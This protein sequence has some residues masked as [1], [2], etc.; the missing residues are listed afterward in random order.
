MITGR[1]STNAQIECIS[2]KK[3]SSGT[4]VGP[5]MSNSDDNQEHREAHFE[6]GTGKASARSV[7][8]G[9]KCKQTSA[10]RFSGQV[11]ADAR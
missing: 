10:D 2:S 6:T 5:D 9:I 11:A 1:K 8:S 4:Q 3:P 7:R